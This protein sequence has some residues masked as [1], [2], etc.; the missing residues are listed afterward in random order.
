MKK[1][2]TWFKKLIRFLVT[3][4]ASREFAFVYC[5]IG[6]IGQ[7]SHTYYLTNSI[8]SFDGWF[9]TFQ[10]ILLS[11]FISGSL[12]YFVSI[13][14]DEK[15]KESKRVRRGINIFTFIEIMINLY[16]YSRHLIIDAEVMLI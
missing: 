14:D 3:I 16:Y 6:T 4:I 8:S 2:I 9:K 15:T 11:A 1:L 5:L 13:S 10:A 7:I 12:L